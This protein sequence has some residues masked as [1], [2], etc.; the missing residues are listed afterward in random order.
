MS[1]PQLLARFPVRQVDTPWGQIQYRQSGQAAQVSHVLLHGI[2]SGSASWVQQLLAAQERT[3]LQLIAWEAPGYGQ[4]SPVAA[5]APVA[6]DYAKRLWAWLDALG[7]SQPVVLVGHSL[8]CLMAA[9]AAALAP[10]RVQRLVLLAPARGY[11]DAPQAERQEK[12]H[13]RLHALEQLGPQ[14]MAAARAP[15]M[16]SPTASADLVEAVRLTMSQIQVQGYTQASHLLV[17]AILRSDVSRVTAAVT[18]ASGEADTITPAA[19]CQQVAEQAGVA[20]QSLGAVGHACPLEAP[21]HVNRL[22]GLV[23]SPAQ[24]PHG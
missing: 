20:W 10:S 11:G 18:V 23:D 17:N 19:A 1:Y 2:G 5:D 3:D 4:S 21:E 13:S 7:V 24:E 12:L 16:L 14:G 22:L 8:G 9:S 6:A 15:A